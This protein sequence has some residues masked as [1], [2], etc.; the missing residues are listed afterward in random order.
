MCRVSEGHWLNGCGTSPKATGIN[1]GLGWRFLDFMNVSHQRCYFKHLPCK[2][3]DLAIGKVVQIFP[4]ATISSDFLFEGI[5]PS[6]RSRC[7]CP[8]DFTKVQVPPPN[9]SHLGG[10]YHRAQKGQRNQR[11]KTSRPWFREGFL[12][13]KGCKQ[14]VKII[15]QMNQPIYLPM[16]WHSNGK[17]AIGFSRKMPEMHFHSWSI[18]LVYARAA[19]SGAVQC[20]SSSF[21]YQVV[22][23]TWVVW[24]GW[25]DVYV[26]CTMPCQ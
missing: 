23:N 13:N 14:T 26:P 12:K 1:G 3:K 9:T 10:W 15:K 20:T 2:I 18:F 24:G 5:P 16:N 19:V 17:S 4:V 6:R 25:R 8:W 7:N 11:K 22:R 21:C